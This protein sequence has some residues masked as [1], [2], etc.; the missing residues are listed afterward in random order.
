MSP[1]FTNFV[2]EFP[3]VSLSNTLPQ[4]ICMLCFLGKLNNVQSSYTHNIC[5][6]SGITGH[7]LY[8]HFLKVIVKSYMFNLTVLHTQDTLGTN[9]LTINCMHIKKNSLWT[10]ILQ[11]H[12]MS[13]SKHNL[14]RTGLPSSCSP[15]PHPW[16]GGAEISRCG[17]LY[18]SSLSKFYKASFMCY[19][20]ECH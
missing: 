2:H 13:S 4:G 11:P 12:N 7:S 9:N 5:I 6:E 16:R 1:S 15:T 17:P 8:H 10:C 20:R 14:N 3:S 18:L 19:L